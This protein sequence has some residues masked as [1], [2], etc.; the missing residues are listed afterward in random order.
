MIFYYSEDEDKD[1]GYE[2]SEDDIASF[3]NSLSEDEFGDHALKYFNEMS[4]KEVHELVAQI[5]DFTDEAIKNEFDA[6]VRD[7]LTPVVIE[8]IEDF[9]EELEEFL[10]DEIKDHYYREKRAYEDAIAYE[11]EQRSE[12]LSHLRSSASNN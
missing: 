1:F 10:A 7:I 5:D 8:H 6:V 9:E 4:E 12:W 3:V 11:E 2:P